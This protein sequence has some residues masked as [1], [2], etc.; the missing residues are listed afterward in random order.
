MAFKQFV[1]STT[2]KALNDAKTAKTVT[3]DDIAFVNEGGVM[4]IQTKGIT[5][6]C[7]YSK[8]EADDRYL[9]L[10]GGTLTGNLNIGTSEDPM[11]ICVGGGMKIDYWTITYGS[12]NV[13]QD[14]LWLSNDEIRGSVCQNKYW[15][16]IL[17][18]P[19]QIRLT[20]ATYNST[21]NKWN[22][23]YDVFYADYQRLAVGNINDTDYLEMDPS[24]GYCVSYRDSNDTNPDTNCHGSWFDWGQIGLDN[25]QV[26]ID[27]DS[28]QFMATSGDTDAYYGRD[29]AW[30]GSESTGVRISGDCVEIGDDTPA[31]ETS[32]L[33]IESNSIITRDHCDGY[34]TG[35]AGGSISCTQ[36]SNPIDLTGSVESTS[37]GTNAIS[38]E[39]PDYKYNTGV[40]V[41]AYMFPDE[42]SLTAINSALHK[43]EI[44]I[45]PSKIEFTEDTRSSTSSKVWNNSNINTIYVPGTPSSPNIASVPC[46]L[47]TDAGIDGGWAGYY[48]TG[49]M[50]S[51]NNMPAAVFKVDY[52]GLSMYDRVGSG[53]S[54]TY[55]ESSR[56]DKTMGV[57][58]DS[59]VSPSDDGIYLSDYGFGFFGYCPTDENFCGLTPTGV[60]LYGGNSSKLVVSDGTMTE[61]KTV[62]KTSIL[63]TGNINIQNVYYFYDTIT[64]TITTDT[65]PITA[66][67]VK[68]SNVY[69]SSDNKL[70]V[71]NV[72]YNY[73]S[74]GYSKYYK[75]SGGYPIDDIGSVIIRTKVADGSVQNSTPEQNNIY[76]NQSTGVS[77]YTTTSSTLAA[78]G[79]A[80][81]AVTSTKIASGAV[82]R[83][84]I[85]EDS[86]TK[87]KIED[88]AV[89]GPKIA[90]GAIDS[91]K[92]V[93]SAV[94]SRVLADNAVTT[95]K[96]ENRAVT[97]AKLANT[98]GITNL[99]VSNLNVLSGTV[100]FLDNGNSTEDGELCI[101]KG[102]IQY[103]LNVEKMY[104]LGLLDVQS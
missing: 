81:G 75:I 67:D 31:N 60:K 7:G 8:A 43:N 12:G 33:K 1:Y 40:S 97:S 3:D 94:D 54:A 62:N 10:T 2:Q 88:G 24:I 51:N 9:K 89:T 21:T 13:G 47:I 25:S 103:K 78:C 29:K 59:Y 19:W 36:F 95:A 55:E 90:N 91:Y 92:M 14:S 100:I 52:Y 96:I 4:S 102:G 45:T 66:T 6:P 44:S 41:Y 27:K 68:V 20:E 61:L 57:F 64:C 18:D 48:D 30:I 83:Y 63:G 22:S 56:L 53:S 82:G 104:E 99:T 15:N 5:F 98:I 93:D 86:I 73:N 16:Q 65:V 23:A 77:Y 34:V 74:S 58:I 32:Y 69:Y 11:N 35:F 50:A 49:D 101:W 84:K 17:C 38:I 39:V 80:D 87:E 71:C 72:T 76:V 42:L 46:G 26:L 79:L 85:A 28:M 70:F 37:I